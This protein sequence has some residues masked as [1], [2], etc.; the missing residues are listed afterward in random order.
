MRW[1]IIAVS[2]GEEIE[3]DLLDD[4][5]VGLSILAAHYCGPSHDN[6]NVYWR[7]W[8]KIQPQVNIAVI[9]EGLGE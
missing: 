2:A 7:A 6:Q 3:S 4:E 5:L 9:G 8:S 1:R